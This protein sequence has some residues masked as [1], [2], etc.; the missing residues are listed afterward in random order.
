MNEKKEQTVT[1][2]AYLY[3]EL[4]DK[5]DLAIAAERL[6]SALLFVYDMQDDYFRAH[7]PT[8]N[9]ISD[10]NA[11]ILLEFPRYRKITNAVA[12][13]LELVKKDFEACG[14]DWR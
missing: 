6:E 3:E 5:G 13:L 1:I 8:A 11:M 14:I 4:I 9:S 7:E 12:S 10:E 2:P